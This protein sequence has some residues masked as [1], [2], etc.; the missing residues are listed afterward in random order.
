MAHKQVDTI[1]RPGAGIVRAMP[2]LL[3]VLFSLLFAN[4]QTNKRSGGHDACWNICGDGRGYYAWLPALFIY[5]DL[6]FHFTDSVEKKVPD[7]GLQS[8]MPIQEYR[9]NFEGRDCNKYY[10]GAAFLMLPFFTI[11]H[12]YTKWFTNLPANGYSIYYFKI[13][14]LSGITYYLLGMLFFLGILTLLRLTDL[15]K[16]LTIVIITFGTNLIY[17]AIDTPAWSHIYSFTIMSAFIYFALKIK[18]LPK[19][20]YLICLSLL[21]GLIF[22]TRPVD[23]V[24]ILVLPFLYWNQ[25]KEIWQQFIKKPVWILYCLPGI[26]F[27]IILFVIYK[28]S[29]G[30]FIIYSYKNEG[31]NFIHPHLWQF[32][33]HFD[34]GILPYTPL[35]FMPLLFLFVWYKKEHKALLLG[36]TTTLI[37]IVYINSSWWFWA[38]GLSFGSRTMLDFLPVYGIPIAL[39]VKQSSGKAKYFLIPVYLFCCALTM[40]LYTQKSSHGYMKLY[41][42]TDYWPAVI[43]G[44][45]IK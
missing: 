32:L 16:C 5:Q 36:I 21:A 6:N 15:H 13:I 3:I 8:G 44:L 25:R 45:G 24:I 35:F 31:F 23:I 11:A 41:H 4:L 42:V 29:T 10:P 27:P 26:M 28:I 1:K 2:V 43:N 37:V 33:F 38:F 12:L 34:N 19:T 20:K 22:I 30:S 18:E 17:Y 9:Y 40:L 14:A 7:C 39:S